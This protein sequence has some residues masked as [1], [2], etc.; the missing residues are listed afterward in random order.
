M[1]AILRRRVRPVFT[2]VA[3]VLVAAC[4][5]KSGVTEP[6][7]EGLVIREVIL[8]ADDGSFT[9][10]HRD[11]WHGAPVVRASGTRGLT[12]HFTSTQ[13]AP[14]EHDTPPVE[15][16]FTLAQAPADYNVRVVIEDTTVARWTGDRVN[17]TLHGLRDGASRISFV[18]RRGGAT[19]YEAPP[20][21]FRVQPAP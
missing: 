10:S 7:V 20:L 16:W 9:F 11:H 1:F 15:S 13:L 14:D 5:D 6:E 2:L 19:I 12:L 8:A 18:V 4:G 21:N 3:V 17:G